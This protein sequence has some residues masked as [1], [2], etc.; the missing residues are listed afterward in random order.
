MP[1][2][3]HLTKEEIKKVLI[4]HKQILRQQGVHRLGLFGSYVRDAAQPDSDIDLL[5]ELEQLSFD[6]YM[7]LKL[8]LEDL[9]GKKVDL[10]IAQSLKPRLKPHI[11]NEVEYVPGL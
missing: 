2:E 10:V 3:R 6:R 4:E 8:F 9:F 1:Q 11:L 7:D 5:V